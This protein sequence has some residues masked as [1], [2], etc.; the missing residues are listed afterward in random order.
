[1]G[2]QLSSATWPGSQVSSGTSNTKGSSS[3][4]RNDA[5][6]GKQIGEGSYGTVYQRGDDAVK[7]FKDADDAAVLL[8]HQGDHRVTGRAQAVDQIRLD[9]LAEGGGDHGVDRGAVS[10]RL[11]APGRAGMEAEQGG[12]SEQAKP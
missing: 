8:R 9:P 2:S 5:E 11:L 4:N 10:R 12:Q 3:S 6:L 1:M 7:C